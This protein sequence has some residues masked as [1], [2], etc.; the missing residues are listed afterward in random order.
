M[1]N[2]TKKWYRCQHGWGQSMVLQL[3]FIGTIL[4]TG[5]AHADTITK[6]SMIYGIKAEDVAFSPDGV[7]FLVAGPDNHAVLR[8]ISDEDVIQIYTGHSDKVTAVAFSQDGTEVLTGSDDNTAKLW[9]ASTGGLIRTFTGHT[10]PVFSVAFSPDGTQVL[11]GSQDCTIKVWSVATG[12]V[13]R[14]FTGHTQPV[15]S[16]TFSSVDAQVLSGSYDNTAMLWDTITAPWVSG[17]S[18][19]AEN[20]ISTSSVYIDVTFSKTVA[21]VDANDMELS[22]AAAASAA[23]WPLV[24]HLGGNTWRFLVTGLANGALNIDLAPDA[25]DIVDQ[26]GNE[27][28]PAPSSWGYTVDITRVNYA[29]ATNSTTVRVIFSEAMVDNASLIDPANYTFSGGGTA[30]TSDSV[31]RINSTTVDVTVNEMTGGAAYTVYVETGPSGPTSLEGNYLDSDYNSRDFTGKGAGPIVTDFA[32]VPESTIYASSVDIDVTFSES[33]TG[34]EAGDMV[35]TGVASGPLTAVGMPTDQGGNTWRFPVSGLRNGVLNISLAPNA[36]DIEDLIG[37]DLDPSPTLWSYRVSAIKLKY[38]IEMT[39]TKVCM[40]FNRPMTNNAAL[41]DPMN[42]TFTGGG[43]VLTA[44]AVERLYSDRIAVTVN[45][46]TDGAVY[47]AH[48]ETGPTGPTDSEGHHVDPL[49]SSVDF[50]GIG[51]APTVLEISPT[52]DTMIY[53]SSA[54]IDVTFSEAVT[55]VDIT[56]LLPSGVGVTIGAPTDLGNNTWRFP[57]SGI[58]NGLNTFTFISSQNDIEDLA[59]NDLVPDSTSWDYIVSL[60]STPPTAMI[61]LQTASPTS[62]DA[63]QFGVTFDEPVAPTFDPGAVILT[64]DLNGTVAVS[65]TDPLYTVIVTLDAPSAD[66]TVGIKVGDSSIITDP[67]GNPY[68]GGTSPVCD[69]FNW[70]GFTQQPQNARSYAGDPHTFTAVAACDAET[71]S[72]Q[73]KWDDGTKAIH[74]IG[75]DSPSCTLPDVTGLAGDYWCEVTYDG[76]THQSITA[77]LEVA[78]HLVIEQQPAGGVYT[79]GESCTF[80]VTTTGGYAPLFYIWKKDGIIVLETAE[81]SLTLDVLTEEDEGEYTVEIIDDNSDVVISDAANL[82]IEPGIAASNDLVLLILTLLLISVSSI[83]LYRRT[84]TAS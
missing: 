56:N 24:E 50:T 69:V 67:A 77:T 81:P 51:I 58:N 17:L 22:G 28:T 31:T 72:Y 46:M 62:A 41:H 61:T 49:Y 13:L 79:T 15:S 60:D 19:A 14:T 23:V 65:G 63:I 25:N 73:W 4:L 48:A 18:P 53:T 42:Y 66:G 7:Y 76:S 8:S 12:I 78:E 38:A 34:V 45:E 74:D 71:L 36:N 52:P 43:V 16:T 10:Q 5:L 75:P 80:N 54:D 84:A 29:Q 9:D 57:V 32:P 20:T 64:G 27:L 44:T 33:V 39:S 1:N 82:E 35:L 70:H 2:N 6:P 68:A 3:L 55:G 83:I 47:T 37:N 11:T 26:D 30:L 21:G 59:D 40:I